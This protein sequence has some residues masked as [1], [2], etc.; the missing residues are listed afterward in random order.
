MYTVYIHYSFDITCYKLFHRFYFLP[1]PLYVQNI[2]WL[3]FT[4]QKFF[5]APLN[6]LR[7]PTRH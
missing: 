6:F 5:V 3:P 2:F 1:P 4:G 7:P